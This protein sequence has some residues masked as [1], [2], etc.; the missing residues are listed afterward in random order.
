M[1]QGRL[2]GPGHHQGGPAGPGHDGGAAGHDRAGQPA[3]PT[4]GPRATPE[5][6]PG[7]LRAAAAGRHRRR[8]PGREP[9]PDGHAAAPEARLLLRPGG[10]GGHHPAR[11]HPG[12][13]GPPV[14]AAARRARAGP[15]PRPPP[16]THPVPDPGRAALPGADA[17]DRHGHGRLQRRRGREPAQG[18]ELPPVRRE[19]G[20]GH[21]QVARGHG[22]QGGRPGGRRLHRQDRGF[23]RPLRLPR[24]ACHQLRAAGLR[25]RLPEGPPGPGVL[26][27]AAQQPADGLLLAGHAAPRCQGPRGRRTPGLRGALRLGD[28]RGGR[29][30]APSRAVPGAGAS[31]GPGREPPG[32][33][34]APTLRLAR[35]PQGADHPGRGGPAGT[36]LHRRAQRLVDRPALRPVAGR[37]P[38]APRGTARQARRHRS[39]WRSEGARVPA[40]PHVARRAPGRRL[41]HTAAHHRTASDGAAAGGPEGDRL[42]ERPTP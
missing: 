15:L 30:I 3:R 20:P 40:G 12:R 9:R 4:R 5:G 18:P 10:R 24:I 29:R 42:A 31:Q 13:P 33:T 11:P 22:P 21:G 7:H 28:P 1:G 36:G 2:R 37:T 32:R 25:Q 38:P 19:D 8:L 39:H 6:R 35:R 26:R 41:R 34:C 14:P 16:R 27:R 23:V 17:R